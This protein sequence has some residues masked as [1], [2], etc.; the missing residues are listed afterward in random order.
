MNSSYKSDKSILSYWLCLSTCS[1]SDFICLLD[2]LEELDFGVLDI[3]LSE[4]ELRPLYVNHLINYYSTHGI[5][6]AKYSFSKSHLDWICNKGL[7]LH[8]QRLGISFNYSETNPIDFDE[9]ILNF[10]EL[11]EIKCWDFT[12]TIL[13]MLSTYSPKLRSFKIL[14]DVD[15]MDDNNKIENFLSKCTQLTSLHISSPQSIDTVHLGSDT[16]QLI[17]K[18]TCTHLEV[19]KLINWDDFENDAI[20]AL[21]KLNN[22]CELALGNV[23]LFL[24]DGLARLVSNNKRLESLTLEGMCWSHDDVMRALGASCPLLKHVTLW[25]GY[26]RKFTNVGVLSMVQGCPL[27]ESIK[28]SSSNAGPFTGWGEESEDEEEVLVEQEVS[29]TNDSL[30][31]IAQYC[32]HLKLLKISSVDPLSYDV[33]GLETVVDYCLSLKAIYTD[34]DKFYS[35]D[36]SEEEGEEDDED[37]DMHYYAEGGHGY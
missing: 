2:Y 32:P 19:L 34:S 3:A 27:L 36:F 24:S 10:P 8:V 7:N 20:L 22:L 15:R 12:D 35:V 28:L 1:N 18:Y 17:A 5:I 14:Y 4:K 16:I 25:S 23:G 29:F 30:F 33:R 21:S 26:W 6:I 13:D 31:A 9:Y 11:L 37:V